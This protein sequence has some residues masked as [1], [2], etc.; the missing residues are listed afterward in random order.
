MIVL[1]NG[2]NTIKI[3]RNSTIYA[4]P[5][6]MKLISNTTNEEYYI[7]PHI[8]VN[9][10]YWLLITDYIEELRNLIKNFDKDIYTLIVTDS[11]EKYIFYKNFVY[12]DGYHSDMNYNNIE[13]Y[14]IKYNDIEL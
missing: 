14:N 5:T 3:I 9:D 6:K 7:E 1:N 13:D 11:D 8:E 10:N 2:Q 12:Y 4:V